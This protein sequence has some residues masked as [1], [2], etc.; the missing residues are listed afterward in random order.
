MTPYRKMLKAERDR[1]EKIVLAIRGSYDAP[2]FDC[3]V[4]AELQ[5]I[6]ARRRKRMMKSAK[7]RSTPLERR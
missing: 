5:E 6:R 4:K 2:A 1:A 3:C 7:G